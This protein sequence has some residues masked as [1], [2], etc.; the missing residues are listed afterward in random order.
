M[1]TK[2]ADHGRAWVLFFLV[3]LFLCRGFFKGLILIDLN[4][5][6][7]KLFLSAMCNVHEWALRGSLLP[8][9]NPLT[10]C[11]HPLGVHA[12]STYNILNLAS[13][14]MDPAT[15]YSVMKFIS[16]FFNAVF[17]YHFLRGKKIS[18]W[19]AMVAALLW[20]V[21]PQDQDAGFFL[22]PLIFLLADRYTEQPKQIFFVALT[23]AMVFFD[24]NTNPQY[25]IYTHLFLVAYL[26]WKTRGAASG[27]RRMATVLL[28]VLVAGGLTSFYWFRAFELL[29]LSSRSDRSEVMVLLPTHY[30]LYLFPKLFEIYGK[31]DLGYVIPRILQGIFS[32]SSW[33]QRVSVF[34]APA[35]VGI[36]SI[37]AFLFYLFLP[38]KNKQESGDF[39]FFFS[40]TV[41]ILVYLTLNPFLYLLVVRHLPIFQGMTGVVRLFLYV[42]FSMLVVMAFSLEQW[43]KREEAG[44]RLLGNLAKGI[45]GVVFLCLS[46]L[47][48][49]K[50]LITLNHERFSNLIVSNL[51]AKNNPSIF[52]GDFQT[53]SRQRV[54][55]FF[56]FFDQ[57]AS[58]LN[59]NILL[60]VVFIAAFLAILWFYGS[61]RLSRSVFQAAF[62]LLAVLDLGLVVGFSRPA[63]SRE[64]VFNGAEPARFF[65][66][67]KSLFRILMVEDS[68]TPY[69]KMF[70]V[71][72]ENMNYHL[73]T[74]DGY[75]Y[76]YYK[77]YLRFYEWL[78]LR[79]EGA[80]G[81]YVHPLHHFQ[82]DL[83]DFL[84]CKYF[85]TSSFNTSLDGQAGYKK[86][87]E[88][89]DYKVYENE[90]VLPRAF[91]VYD[92][93]SFPT[94][95]QIGAYIQAHPARLKSEVVL[96]GSETSAGDQTPSLPRSEATIE[97]YTP[98]EVTLSAQLDHDGYLVMTEN[99]YPGWNA[100]VD[101]KKTPILKADYTFRALRLSAGKH[102]IRLWFDP[103]SLK[104]G[105]WAS[106]AT[107]VFGI[108]ALYNWRLIHTSGKS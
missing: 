62:I 52:I 105:L 17:F 95:R 56:Y 28:P 71:S 49:V 34:I 98:E 54:A 90:N 94:E 38:K 43:L 96:M 7:M 9:W 93:I 97:K 70:L 51:S 81:A 30:F 44:R 89:P 33:T 20:I 72:E 74:P 3:S 12:V 73:A 91:V 46:G 69:H 59:P 86:V 99:N 61:K 80:V 48:L 103:V 32:W 55:E 27:F 101:G 8:L 18:A 37:L 64:A 78:T 10:L 2:L 47:W 19:P 40:A 67:D 79:S 63:W 16:F 35:Y 76:F 84:N 39:R 1:R 41:G 26:L 53:F 31:P 77:P 36:S 50:G 92:A 24:L 21:I 100:E 58:L 29:Q 108:I 14:V 45:G 68:K 57:W 88:N 42:Q 65:Q 6:E 83:A 66:Q 106:L 23:I 87:W 5:D 15:V 102:A 107:L 60:P 4:S 13:L 75:E 22:L 82:P 25:V 85:L 11:G 104:V